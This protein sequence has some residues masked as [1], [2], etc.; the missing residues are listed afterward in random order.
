[1]VRQADA[2]AEASPTFGRYLAWGSLPCSYWPAPATGRPHRITAPGAAPILV[3][4]TERDPA[5]PVEWARALADQLESGELLLWDGDGH[6]AYR[7]GS[8]CVDQAVDR[9]LLEGRA[10]ADGTRCR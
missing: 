10:P 1:V 6:T 4:G 2:L 5:T 9:Y 7:H 8:T 3:V